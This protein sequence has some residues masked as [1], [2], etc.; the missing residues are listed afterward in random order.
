VSLERA[1]AEGDRGARNVLVG[2][3]SDTHGLLRPEAVEALRGSDLILHAGD[4]GGQ[5]ILEALEAMAPVVAVRGNTDGGA[6]G[7]GLSDTQVVEVAESLI[8]VLHDIGAL[9]LDPAAAGLA[10]VVFG[11]SHRPEIRKDRGVL[12]FNPG[13]AGHRRFDN[14][15]TVGRIR[16]R[17]GE[18]FAE[19]VDL[20]GERFRS[21]VAAT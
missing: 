12:Y 1:H 2:V 21:G 18:L 4:V 9:D 15:I 7:R 19:V 14:P 6:F 3:I 20:E 17:E 5:A 16:V 8:Y 10:A 11:H 13:S